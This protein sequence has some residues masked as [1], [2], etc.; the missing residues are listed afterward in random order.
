MA[1]SPAQGFS[2]AERPFGVLAEKTKAEVGGAN[3]PTARYTRPMMRKSYSLAIAFIALLAASQAAPRGAV[4]ATAVPGAAARK[5]DFPGGLDME[6]L[7]A[8]TVFV[9]RLTRDGVPGVGLAF[10]LNASRDEA[11]ALLT[12]DRIITDLYPDCDE[13]IVH[14]SG[15]DGA[16]IEYHVTILF[17]KYSYT[18]AMA[19]DRESYRITWREAGG[20]FK[21][22]GGYWE[23][24]ET[25]REGTSLLVNE[26]LLETG[27]RI[28]GWLDSWV[29]M[30][31]TRSIA[32]DF[33]KW[34]EQGARGAL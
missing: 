14:R 33:R 10:T 17:K 16:L 20:D 22:I 6:Q 13:A 15:P 19:Y 8:G 30:S 28:P 27:F 12:D 18:L 31:K 4:A 21:R 25:G 7:L 24:R 2:E 11:W 3:P 34:V 26:S 29:K 32:A 23:V 5:P 9:E 1:P